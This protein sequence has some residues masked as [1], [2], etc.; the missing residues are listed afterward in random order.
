MT[1]DEQAAKLFANYHLDDVPRIADPQRKLYE[2]FELKRGSASQVM[3]PG[4]WWKGFKTTIL[5]GH[6][7]GMPEGTS[8]SCRARSWWP[9]VRSCRAFRPQN[10]ADHPDYA[11]FAVCELPGNGPSGIP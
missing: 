7:P 10:S 5:R 8:F 6:L 1:T 11:E 9:T 4:V 2:A 3:G